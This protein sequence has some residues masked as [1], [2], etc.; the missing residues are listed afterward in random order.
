MYNI[1]RLYKNTDSV[2]LRT[3]RISM[4]PTHSGMTIPFDQMTYRRSLV[5]ENVME[6]VDRTVAVISITSTADS[7]ETSTGNYEWAL[8]TT[9]G[10]R[11]DM[12]D[13]PEVGEDV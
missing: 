12:K 8:W 9:P 4:F 10:V 11:C 2:V 13:L 1:I 5:T 3:D 6:V 7:Y